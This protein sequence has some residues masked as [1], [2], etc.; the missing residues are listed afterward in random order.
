[1]S[2]NDSNRYN[3]SMQRSP[4]LDLRSLA[5]PHR[6]QKRRG[7]VQCP[8][9]TLLPPFPS[10]PWGCCLPTS[11]A[12][13]RPVANTCWTT[14]VVSR[15]NAHSVV[16]ARRHRLD[17][18]PYSTHARRQAYLKRLARPCDPSPSR[19]PRPRPRLRRRITRAVESE[20]SHEH[21]TSLSLSVVVMYR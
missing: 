6:L 1:M 4:C 21:D 8:L 15:G 7:H 20:S 13:V 19:G 14:S 16:L 11:A 3:P 12:A 2:G 10:I 9:F 17:W 18:K 5:S